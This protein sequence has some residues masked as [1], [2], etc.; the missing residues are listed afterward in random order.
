MSDNEQIMRL[1]QEIQLLRRRVSELEHIDHALPHLSLRDGVTAPSAASGAALLYIDSVT[2][3]LSIKYS[4][5]YTATVQ[6]DS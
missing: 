5:G 2:G 1:W 3:D 4:D 6:A